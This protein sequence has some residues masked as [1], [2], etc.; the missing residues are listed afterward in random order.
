M[1]MLALLSPTTQ[2]WKMP[3]LGRQPVFQ[4]LAKD[5][6]MESYDEESKDKSIVRCKEYRGEKLFKE[7]GFLIKG[8]A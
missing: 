1:A 5:Y 6:L 3:G 4:K 7:F 8:I 2:S